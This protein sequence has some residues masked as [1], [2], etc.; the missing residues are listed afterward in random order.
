MI[1]GAHF[2]VK[3]AQFN[4]SQITSSSIRKIEHY[5]RGYCQTRDVNCSVGEV[6]GWQAFLRPNIAIIGCLQSF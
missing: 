2:G 4:Y 1:T 5:L 3:K 6:N